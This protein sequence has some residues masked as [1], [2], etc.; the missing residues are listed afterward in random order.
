MRQL[1]DSPKEKCMKKTSVF[2]SVLGL[3]MVLLCGCAEVSSTSTGSNLLT[4]NWG[5]ETDT[6][7]NI[8]R[9]T[10]VIPGVGEGSAK[11]FVLDSVPW[12]KADGK[13]W[14]QTNTFVNVIASDWNT[15]AEF[16][17]SWW[18]LDG[19]SIHRWNLKDPRTLSIEDPMLL[20]DRFASDS[21]SYYLP[22]EYVADFEQELSGESSDSVIGVRFSPFM[23]DTLT[24]GDLAPNGAAKAA[25]L[26]RKDRIISVNGKSAFP[27][28]SAYSR[29]SDS[30][31]VRLRIFRPSSDSQFEVTLTR[32]PARFPSVWIDT[33]SGGRGYIG[34]D[35]FVSDSDSAYSTG[36]LVVKAAQ[37]L[38]G[39]VASGGW[40]IL[41]LRSNPGGNVESVLQSAAALVPNGDSTIRIRSRDISRTTYGG[42]TSDT[43]YMARGAALTGRKFAVLINSSTASAA[44]M[45][46]SAIRS[47]LYATGD[48]TLIGQK[49]FGKGIGQNLIETPV[50]A[51][52][53]ITS[54]EI[55]PAGKTHYPSYD[56]VGISPDQPSSSA[57]TDA[58]VRTASSRAAGRGAANQQAAG[59]A[60]RLQAW[61]R[62]QTGFGKIGTL[63]YRRLAMKQLR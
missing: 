2:V 21:F 30:S 29:I 42:V 53:R 49:T 17:Y 39:V 7:G 33:L 35:Q 50:G 34:I 59:I 63:A 1:R 24:I 8:V 12:G 55:L 22:A 5:V 16:W 38:S 9:L 44:E 19:L 13:R 3:T 46:T 43:T 28:D 40:I 48:A 47:N 6:Q 37:A 23:T 57:L 31:K 27:V 56:G 54:L 4:S 14:I 10:T 26:W 51:C 61:N 58:L 41:D 45:L 20:F 62:S 60:E 36:P 11:S 18:Y 25:G 15:S 52:L 32:A